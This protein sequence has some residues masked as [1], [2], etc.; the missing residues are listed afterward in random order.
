MHHTNLSL[1][2]YA[3]YVIEHAM[4]PYAHLH[5][6]WLKF[7]GRISISLPVYLREVVEVV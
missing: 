6:V 2:W 1:T 4:A 3:E 7:P 5:V